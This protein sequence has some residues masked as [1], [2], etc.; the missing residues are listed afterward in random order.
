MENDILELRK[1][2][3]DG[4]EISV[5]LIKNGDIT[6]LH[7]GQHND[8][9]LIEIDS[10]S[11]DCEETFEEANAIKIQNGVIIQSP[12]VIL[13]PPGLLFYQIYFEE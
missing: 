10:G 9:D 4:V 11:E 2:G 8:L 5:N 6:R 3:D 1:S 12:C 7:F 13:N